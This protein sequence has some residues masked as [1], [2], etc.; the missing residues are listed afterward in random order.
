MSENNNISIG[1]INKLTKAVKNIGKN[2]TEKAL[3]QLSTDP[4]SIIINN[5]IQDV[6]KEYVISKKSLFDTNNKAE[7]R[8]P[9]TAI[10]VYL[11]CKYLKIS[12]GNLNNYLP[13]DDMQRST[14]SRYVNLIARLNSKILCEKRYIEMNEKLETKMKLYLQN[15]NNN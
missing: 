2:N 11:I 3:V 1:L 4:V 15:I 5:L 13:I 14:I 7:N 12:Y 9:A 6:C 8:R 10:L